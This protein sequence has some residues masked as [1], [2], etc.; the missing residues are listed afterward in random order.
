[1]AFKKMENS[2]EKVHRISLKSPSITLFKNFYRRENC[3]YY[4]TEEYKG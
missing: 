2:L 4:L 3:V 1:M